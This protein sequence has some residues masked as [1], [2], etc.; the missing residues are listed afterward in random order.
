MRQR[1]IFGALLLVALGVILGAT[2]I[3]LGSDL[4]TQG[5]AKKSRISIRSLVNAHQSSDGTYKGRFVLIL[6]G[7]NEDS[8]T[9]FIRPGNGPLKTVGG[10]DQEP[11]FAARSYLTGKKGTLGILFRGVSITVNNIDPAKEAS[12]I[13]YGTW[14][15]TAGTG[16]YK[17]WK[18][19]GR[20]ATSF[21]PSANH[22]EW[23]GYVTH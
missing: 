10:Q 1:A 21:S 12:G 5:A 2:G 9:N 11:I 16:I 17:G 8:G 18:G 22:V 3:A 19:G 13:E 4:E 15:I 7:A 23:D 20:W 14:H 6:D